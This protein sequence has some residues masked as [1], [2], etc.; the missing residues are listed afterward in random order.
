[1]VVTSEFHDLKLALV[2]CGGMGRRHLHGLAQLVDA[3]MCPF[4]LT[5]VCD[6]FPE[7]GA[8]AAEL[9]AQLLGV[10][11]QVYQEF[12]ELAKT[13][14]PD[15]VDVVTTPASHHT[16]AANALRAGINVQV[17]KPVALTIAAADFL[18]AAA[19]SETVLSVAENYRRDPLNRL[20][21]ALVAS[22]VL[23]APQMMLDTTL[24]GGGAVV[25]TPWRSTR[26][27][28]GLLL[29]V[30]VHHADILEYFMGPLESV[31]AWSRVL[32]PERDWQGLGGNL[33]EF[34]QLS[35]RTVHGSYRSDGI[36]SGFALLRFK[37]GAG[38]QWTMGL[39]VGGGE[40]VRLRRIYLEGG[41]IECPEDRSGH[42]IRVTPRSGH[43]EISGEAVLDLVPDFELPD[44]TARLFGSSRIGRI[45]L[46][47]NAIDARITASEYWELGDCILTGSQPEVG[48]TQGRSALATVLA[49]IESGIVGTSVTIDQILTGSVS[50]YQDPL[51]EQLAGIA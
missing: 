1:M 28:G 9:A 12:A 6:P 23:G 41:M 8:A 4:S 19:G 30:G 18:A 43:G 26:A 15:A 38:G 47:F 44:A 35:N 24:S 25:I 17:E 39:G 33:A 13:E 46:G 10:R 49:V 5:A 50:T 40:R 21:R 16:V 34:Y 42:P 7:A 14:A 51:N 2:G 3:G 11:P 27:E 32:E 31:A 48:I 45:E 37:S 29:D 22:G 20:V 36:D